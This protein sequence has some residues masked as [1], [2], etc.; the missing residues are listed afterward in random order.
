M[1]TCSKK[2]LETC[3]EPGMS[4]YWTN[5]YLQIVYFF[6][7]E[8]RRQGRWVATPHQALCQSWRQ[9]SPSQIT[10]IGLNGS[11]LA[12]PLL[13]T[14]LFQYLASLPD[15]GFY[16][17]LLYDSNNLSLAIKFFSFHTMH[18]FYNHR[19]HVTHSHKVRWQGFRQRRHATRLSKVGPRVAQSYL[20]M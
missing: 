6:G 1:A 16:L 19:S 17:L 13:F 20:P 9:P 18:F 4:A 15:T 3:L 11:P 5:N 8:T 2:G 14:Y 12:L 7:T 10:L